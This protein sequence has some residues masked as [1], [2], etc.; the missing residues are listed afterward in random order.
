MDLVIQQ[1]L[2]ENTHL[3]HP[4]HIRLWRQIER[5][6]TERNIVSLTWA[7]QMRT[8]CRRSRARVGPLTLGARAMM[9]PWAGKVKK[10]CKSFRWDSSGWRIS[11]TKQPN[12]IPFG[13]LDRPRSHSHQGAH[14]YS[15]HARLEEAIGGDTQGRD[16]GADATNRQGQR[17]I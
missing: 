3:Q 15:C 11:P 4:C 17:V 1:E 7:E 6:D 9:S 12:W 10:S 16:H 14:V 2:G 5:A 13:Y 8:S